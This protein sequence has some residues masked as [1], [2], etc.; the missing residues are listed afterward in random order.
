MALGR[1]PRCSDPA[2]RTAAAA[3]IRSAVGYVPAAEIRSAVGSVPA[4]E[5]RSAVGS[6]VGPDLPSC[7]VIF[8]ATS[9]KAQALLHARPA[10][11]PL[12]RPSSLT[13]SPL[14]QQ[15]V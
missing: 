7:P 14:T 1:V 9:G 13:V 12:R 3:E 5:I 11:V 15:T 8:A 10:P 2:R 4:A 6:A